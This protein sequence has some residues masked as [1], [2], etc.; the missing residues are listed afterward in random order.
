[1]NAAASA[2]PGSGAKLA[3]VGF[4]TATE[5]TSVAVARDGEVLCESQLGLSEK[6]GPLHTTALLEEVERVV[7]AVGGW[8]S[9]DAIAVG[10]GPGSFTG[11]RVGVS[12]ARALGFSCGLP[13]KGVCTLDAL[14]LAM[15]EVAGA[16]SRLAVIDARRG[17]VFAALYAPSGERLWEPLVSPPDSLAQRVTELEESPLA[18]G[19]GAIRFR[20]ELANR[21]VEVPDDVDPVHRVAARHI[22]ALAVTGTSGDDAGPVAPIY[23][24]PPDAQRWRERDTSQTAK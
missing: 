7:A 19:S 14:G 23:L 12:T 2:D 10:V 13:V 21:G 5:D 22:C 11:L 4:D 1:L 20:G 17:E 3:V 6:G 16:S 8:K 24:R 15:G 18:A 9:I